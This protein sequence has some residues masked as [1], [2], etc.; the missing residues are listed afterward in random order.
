[1]TSAPTALRKAATST[2]QVYRGWCCGWHHSQSQVCPPPSAAT[3]L[4][5]LRVAFVW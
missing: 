4:R 5:A 3:V 2:E 1:M